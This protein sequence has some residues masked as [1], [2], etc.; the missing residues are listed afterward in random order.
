MSASDPVATLGLAI[1]LILVLAKLGGDLA[2]RLRQPPVLGELFAG[3]V[4]GNIPLAPLTSIRSDPYVDVLARL[5]AVVLLFEIGL[6]TTVREVMQVGLAAARVALLGVVATVLLGWWAMALTMPGAPTLLHVFMAAAVTATSVGVS[7]RVL[8]DSAASR[9]C[10]AH[11]ILAAA[12]IDDVLVLLMLAIFSSSLARSTASA[13]RTAWAIALLVTK[14]LSFLAAALWVGVK[15]SPLLFRLTSRLRGKGALVAMGLAFCFILAWASNAIGLAPIVGAFT[16]G[17][18]LEESHSSLFVARG[19]HSLSERMEPISSW[20]V[21]IFFVVLGTRAQ[22]RSFAHLSTLVLIG[23]LA[24]AAIAGKIG[25]ALGAPRGTDRLA[26]AFGMLPRGE[27]SLVFAGLG[28]SLNL[29]DPP[30]YATI[31]A[32]VVVT[33]LITPGALRWRLQRGSRH[34][35]AEAPGA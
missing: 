24:A 4:L 22:L 12:V 6:E 33:T 30:Q 34:D 5:G 29:L 16:A 32:V 2:S 31:L 18:I 35:Q 17:L 25:C 11:T 28:T 27:V 23:S 1:A 7:A 19:E 21:P 26:I 9:T 20:L 15:L 8:K 13:A 10:E 3:I 14:T